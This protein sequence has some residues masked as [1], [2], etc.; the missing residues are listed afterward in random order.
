MTTTIILIIAIVLLAWLAKVMMKGSSSGKKEASPDSVKSASPPEKDK[1]A[2]SVIKKAIS[3]SSDIGVK[4]TDLFR[5]PS[6]PEFFAGRKD[7]M[8]KIMAS[9]SAR[10]AIVGISGFSGVGKTCLAITMIGKLSS[11][12]PKNCLFVDMQ[13]ESP[14]PPSA[15]DI[16][17]RIILKFHPT[18][19]I[20]SDNKKLAKL[21]RAA[22]KAHKGILILDDVS[23]ADQVK[24]LVPPSSWMLMFTSTKP[25]LIP[26]M[27][28]ID[29]EPLEILDAHTLLNQLAPEISPS[30]KEIAPICKGVSLALE[31]I[32]RLFA[33]N[34]TMA[35]DYFF[36]KFSEERKR[37]GEDEKGNLI[38]GVR[39]SISLSYKMLPDNTAAVLRKL[40][41]FPGSFTANAVSF[42][43]EDPKNLSL[44]GL[45]KFGLVQYN[46]NNNRYYLHSQLKSFLKP[47]LTPGD[48]GIAERRLAT[49]FMNV[50][51]SAHYHV[52]KEGKEALKGLRLFDMELEN[53]KA[54]MEWSRK[55]CTQDKEAAQMCSAYTEHA[56]TLISKRLSPTEC[57]TWF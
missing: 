18:Q 35:P 32:G 10:P 57:I 56:A 26:K 36:K 41:V 47:L 8:K 37:F 11:H 2:S 49:E 45:E 23:N 33:I 54:G 12:F 15:E 38:D 1:K 7:E 6:E 40:I 51:E 31:V 3:M 43:C 19:A 46:L 5:P 27:T 20:P 29:L 34:S 24:P 53:I 9:A 4:S 50:L 25:V 16:M 55:F 48:R 14:N 39:A 28:A 21:Y 17:R 42:I 30:I 44:T 52:D 13:G 22:L